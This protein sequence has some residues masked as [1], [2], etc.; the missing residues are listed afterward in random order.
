MASVKSQLQQRARQ[1][2]GDPRRNAQ[3]SHH[4]PGTLGGFSSAPVIL[5]G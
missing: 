2:R 4:P 3:H 5:K 1:P